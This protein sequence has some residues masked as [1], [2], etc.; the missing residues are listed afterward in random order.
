MTIHDVIAGSL[1]PRADA[2]VLL[3][4]LLGRD[5]TWLYA[6]PEYALTTE[7]AMRWSERLE[8]RR[9]C[10]PVAYILGEQ[11]FRGRMFA[12][13]TRVL[14]P[15][16]AT[17][18]VVECALAFLRDRRE[19]DCEADSR[20]AVIARRAARSDLP[21]RLVV[22]IGTGSGCIAITLLLEHPDLRAI[23]TDV[24]Q[25]A[26]DVAAENAARHGVADRIAFRQG[27]GFEPILDLAEPFLI[28]ANPPYIP[29]GRKLMKDVEGYEPHVALFGG[30]DGADLVRA[31]L[32]GAQAHPF[33]VGVVLEC[34]REQLEHE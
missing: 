3:A 31:I 30:A 12:V 15:R 19:T 28:A 14:I 9:R 32:A 10:E 25:D 20:I 7:E 13:D 8:R 33:C 4:R 24:S 11:E 5:R 6:H 2:E 1:L 16:P 23:A 18:A 17:E 27:N 26:L 22:D 34:G 29:A 21:A